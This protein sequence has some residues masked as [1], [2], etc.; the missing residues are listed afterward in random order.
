MTYETA[1]WRAD[2]ISGE[3]IS[4][5]RSTKP[6]EVQTNI[7][8]PFEVLPIMSTFDACTYHG[9]PAIVG[10]MRKEF[11]EMPKAARRD[12]VVKVFLFSLLF[13]DFSLK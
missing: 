12:A 3:I 8:K 13:V 1:F 7:L 4:S 2:G 5:G 6:G 10:F 11:A 9:S